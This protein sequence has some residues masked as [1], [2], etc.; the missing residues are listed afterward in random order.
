MF[1]GIAA[2]RRTGRFE[3]QSNIYKKIIRTQVWKYL[4]FND[5]KT[6]VT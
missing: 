3:T 6:Y 1:I 4:A 2:A 5:A